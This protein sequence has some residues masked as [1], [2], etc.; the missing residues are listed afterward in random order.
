[1]HLSLE[2]LLAVAD[3]A[4]CPAACEHV[5][6]CPACAA[7]LERLRAVR[8]ELAALPALA[9]A[10]DLWTLLRE[11][12]LANRLR[13]RVVLV[14]W[15]AAS[16]AVAISLAA[17][18]RGAVEGWHEM[19]TA[20]ATKSLV[21]E[22]QRLEGTLRSLGGSRVVS[23]RTAGVIVTLEDRIA[24]VDSRLAGY[25][26][27]GASSREMVDLWQE[28]VRLLDALVNVQASR[29]TYVGL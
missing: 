10:S 8:Q 24:R 18:V 1:M 27:D 6:A 23:A 5:T 13:R 17:A 28:R 9:P 4:A 25:S 3:G 29:A 14:G 15:L 11:E 12:A 20:Q 21:A 2:E 22:S 19:K 7:E 16:L 26:R